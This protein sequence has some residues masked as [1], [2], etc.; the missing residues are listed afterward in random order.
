MYV[1][2]ESV[3]H[4][5]QKNQRILCCFCV[6]NFIIK[7]IVEMA[8]GNLFSRGHDE[9]QDAVDELVEDIK[10]MVSRGQLVHLFIQFLALSSF[11]LNNFEI[12]IRIPPPEAFKA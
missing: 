4:D 6:T 11:R 12:Q 7:R 3:I 2:T 1:C 10:D 9:G 8:R 5:E